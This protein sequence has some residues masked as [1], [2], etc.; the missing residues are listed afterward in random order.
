MFLY[1]KYSCFDHC[2]FPSYSIYTFYVCWGGLGTSIFENS[3]SAANNTR[4][5]PPSRL[6][7]RF[8]WLFKEKYGK[9]S[10]T[11]IALENSVSPW[12]LENIHFGTLV[13][14]AWHNTVIL[15]RK[16]KIRTSFKLLV[17]EKETCRLKETSR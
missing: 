7:F 12:E 11:K 10:K 8:L 17:S 14:L 3:G 1:G 9:E 13:L 16:N 4:F 15:E 6:S 2:D 5:R